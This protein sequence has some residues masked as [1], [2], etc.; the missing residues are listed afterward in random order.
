MQ[1]WPLDLPDPVRRRILALWSAASG[2]ASVNERV[3]ALDALAQLQRD[4]ELSDVALNFIA[5]TEVQQPSKDAS[6]SIPPNL[7][8]LIVGLVQQVRIITTVEN[9]LT[10]AF[11]TL[12][13]H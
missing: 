2:A 3:K 9:A 12:H 4:H 5:E 11:W 10:G 1:Q 7:I 8:A 13:T 6:E